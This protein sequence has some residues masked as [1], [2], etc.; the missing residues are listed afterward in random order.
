MK[1]KYFIDMLTNPID[2]KDQNQ[3]LSENRT[4]KTENNCD[5][6]SSSQW[7]ETDIIMKRGT[8]ER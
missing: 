8:S 1:S 7:V 2:A 4:C 6:F 5:V 3:C